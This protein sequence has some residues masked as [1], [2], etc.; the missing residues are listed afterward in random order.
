VL[1]DATQ[2]R[3]EI[4]LAAVQ[5]NR[6]TLRRNPSFGEA[7]AKAFEQREAF[8]PSTDPEAQLYD[9]FI[10]D[11]DKRGLAAVRSATAATITDVPAFSDSRLNELLF[12]YKARWYPGTLSEAESL[13]WEQYRSEKLRGQLPKYL[14]LLQANAKEGKDSYLIEELQLWAENVAPSDL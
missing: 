13:K 4:D 8:K 7:I 12:R 10:P 11:G 2:Q 6:A 1:D 3:L 9:G 14:V 5:A